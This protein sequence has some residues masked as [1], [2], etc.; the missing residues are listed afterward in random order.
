MQ[1][2]DN[3]VCDSEM[4]RR[5]LL[6]VLKSLTLALTSV[7]SDCWAACLCT[8]IISF[9]RVS[10]GFSEA[11]L[12]DVQSHK[13]DLN[14][15]YLATNPL[16]ASALGI[17]FLGRVL[18]TSGHESMEVRVRQ[19]PKALWHELTSSKKALC[20]YYRMTREGKEMM[21]RGQLILMKCDIMS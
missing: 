12:P 5:V 18:P 14:S 16:C 9:Q 3:M 1:T 13:F 6:A 10:V 7:T 4:K 19:E 17:F 20:V 8:L 2:N 11:H 15:S 21:E